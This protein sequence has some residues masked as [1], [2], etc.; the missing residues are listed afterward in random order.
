MY[1]Y[2]DKEVMKVCKFLY[3]FKKI[4]FYLFIYLFFLNRSYLKF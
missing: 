4:L 2:E 1:Y 3:T